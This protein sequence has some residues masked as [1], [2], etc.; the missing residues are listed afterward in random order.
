MPDSLV[1]YT[2]AA[3]VPVDELEGTLFL[4]LVGCESLHGEA[5]VRIHP[6]HS[7]DRLGRRCEIDTQTRIGSDLHR[8]FLGYVHREYGRGSYSV[9]PAR[10][11]EER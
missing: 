3:S 6:C 1:R 5:A 10:R 2:F 7:F 4:A 11:E 8:L 9:D